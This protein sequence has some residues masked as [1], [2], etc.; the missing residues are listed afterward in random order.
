MG[1]SRTVGFLARA[2]PADQAGVDDAE[3]AIEF[4]SLGLVHELDGVAEALLGEPLHERGEEA[5][6]NIRSFAPR[7]PVLPVSLDL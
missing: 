5:L 6:Q 7:A 4:G 3:E 1:R 2:C